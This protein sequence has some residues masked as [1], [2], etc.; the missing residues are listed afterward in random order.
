MFNSR[1]TIITLILE[2]NPDLVPS[3]IVERNI[4]DHKVD[5]PNSP[6]KHPYSSSTKPSFQHEEEGRSYEDKE[7]HVTQ[8]KSQ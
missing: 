1:S 7:E 3:P 5:F 8:G 4:H 6:S 2:E